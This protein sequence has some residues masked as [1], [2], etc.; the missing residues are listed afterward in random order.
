M[1]IKTKKQK[2]EIKK[3]SIEL[4]AKLHEEIKNYCMEKGYFVSS[5]AL[6]AM[7]RVMEQENR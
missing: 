4:P 6:Y 5:F 2:E 1:N 3:L 7:T